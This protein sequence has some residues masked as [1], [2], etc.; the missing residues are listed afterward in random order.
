MS[1]STLPTSRS[2]IKSKKENIVNTIN[3]STPACKPRIISDEL[4]IDKPIS[5]LGFSKATSRSVKR[6]PY[7][8]NASIS[9]LKIKREKL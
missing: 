8:S 6:K 3:R 5:L 4:L 2:E 7:Y 9:N 1:K